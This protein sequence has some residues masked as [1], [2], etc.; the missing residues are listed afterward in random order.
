MKGGHEG[1]TGCSQWLWRRQFTGPS[2]RAWELDHKEGWAMKNWCFQTVVLEKVL[3]SP[4]DSKEVKPVNP[5]G[6]N[7]EYSLEDLMLKLK[8][9]YFGH[10]MPRTGS[11]EKTQMLGNIEGRRRRGWQRM[12]WLDGITDSM[13]MGL[14][15]L[16][17]L[18]MDR[19]I[20]RAAVHEVANNQTWL[21]DWIELNW[22]D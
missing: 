2:S 1:S 18:M 22:T 16:W 21:S 5:K 12:S 7:P 17:D 13:D 8:L 14:G 9:Q 15:G 19:E 3:E 4:L 6:I 10:L 20:W 11:L